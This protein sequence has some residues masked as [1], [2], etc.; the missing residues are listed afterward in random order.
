METKKL[1]QLYPMR[2]EMARRNQKSSTIQANSK[3]PNMRDH[4]HQCPKKG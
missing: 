2:E 1:D 3:P 4:L